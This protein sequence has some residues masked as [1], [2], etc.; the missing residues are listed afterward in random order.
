MV[1]REARE[2]LV[3]ALRENPL[4]LHA[5]KRCGVSRATYYRWAASNARFRKQAEA[6]QRVGRSRFCDLAESAIM[7][8]VGRGDVAAAKFVLTHNHPKYQPKRP[9][10]LEVRPYEPIGKVVFSEI[11]H[12][13]LCRKNFKDGLSPGS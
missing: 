7:S 11:G 12:C 13:T 2:K 6:A 4:V 3:E 10:P 1:E 8:A 9:Q 5:C